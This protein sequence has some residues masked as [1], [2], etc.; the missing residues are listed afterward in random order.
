MNRLPLYALA[1]LGLPAC[2][3]DTRGD[4]DEQS[5]PP[6]ADSDTD[7]NDSD[8][9][10]AS[11]ADGDG[12]TIT[13]GDCDDA[14][15][16]VN[17]AA[18]EACDGVDNNCD[19]VTDAGTPCFD[20]DGDGY[21]EEQGDCDDADATSFPEAPDHTTDGIDQDCNGSDGVDCSTLRYH[22]A[23]DGLGQ[24]DCYMGDAP[25]SCDW[26]FCE[27]GYNAITGALYVDYTTEANMDKLWCL[28]AVGGRPGGLGISISMNSYLTDLSGLYNIQQVG[29]NIGISCN[30]SL[31]NAAP[32][33]LVSAI[34]AENIGGSINSGYNGTD[35]RGGNTCY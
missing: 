7:T 9:S 14:D 29:G 34:G 33:A 26:N 22:P 8:S 3:P 16:L 5:D 6:P 10:P 25:N 27:E 11:D 21:S 13:E 32:E 4:Q 18:R 12:F 19:D 2:F 35:Y 23:V 24:G 30:Q 17:P 15:P 20:D 28:C 1:V 31:S